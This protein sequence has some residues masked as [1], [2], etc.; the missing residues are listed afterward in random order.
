LLSALVDYVARVKC[1]GGFKEKYP[2]FF[3]GD[4]SMLHAAGDDD[5][6]A[7]LDPL[8]MLAGIL[9]AIFH[10][11][12]AFD[13]EKEFVFVVVMMPEKSGVGLDELDHLS[14]EFSGDVGLVELGDAGEFFG[15]IYFEH[16]SRP[17]VDG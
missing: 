1:G 6:F 10:A 7:G 16:E 9:V 5:E 17:R 2:A 4:G 3:F 13:D 8:L 14:V 11:E 12:A 15:E